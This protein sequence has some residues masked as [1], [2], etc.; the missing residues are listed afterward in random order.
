MNVSFLCAHRGAAVGSVAQRR[1]RKER[2]YL[3]TAFFSFEP[4]HPREFSCYV[5]LGRKER[6]VS[7]HF[8][9]RSERH[10][11]ALTCMAGVTRRDCGTAEGHEYNRV[12]FPRLWLHRL[13]PNSCAPALLQAMA[14]TMARAERKRPLQFC[15]FRCSHRSFMASDIRR[16]AAS[17]S[18]LLFRRGD[19]RLVLG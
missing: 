18:S 15:F 1:A 9:I 5:S 4:Q 13:L 17:L 6:C 16:L 12:P 7:Y 19:L 2:A 10:A 11:S 8:P 3:E 14:T